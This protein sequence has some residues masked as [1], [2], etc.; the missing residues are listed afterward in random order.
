M[1]INGQN[2]NIKGTQGVTIASS[3]GDVAS[4]GL[5]IKETAQMQYSAKGNASAEV[6]GGA[7]LV[8][9]A[10]MVMIN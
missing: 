3:G 1:G 8:L 6:Q 2:V 4:S 7:Q 9:K 10:A 5:N